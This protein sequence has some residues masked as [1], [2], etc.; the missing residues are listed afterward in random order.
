M[1]QI[2]PLRTI[3]RTMTRRSALSLG[4]AAIASSAF[5]A[6]EPAPEEIVEGFS[7]AG[8]AVIPPLIQEAIDVGGIP[9]VV[10][11]IWRHGQLVQCNTLGLRNIERT[12][13]MERTTLFRIASMSKPI[14]TVAALRLI[15][16]GKMK[17]EDS[18]DKW[19][20]EFSTMRVLQRA[21]G[22]LDETHA[23]RRLSPSRI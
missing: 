17:L 15:E 1:S 11:A 14:T 6:T 4:A 9:G 16:S 12:L 5:A 10:A 3:L 18:I 20:P 2:R 23:A 21:D 13:P 22:R 8:L 7:V 19:A